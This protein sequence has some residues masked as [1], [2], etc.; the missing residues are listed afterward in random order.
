M[1]MNSLF[2]EDGMRNFTAGQ[3][4]SLVDWA[5]EARQIAQIMQA[6]LANQHID[7]D[8]GRAPNRR[9]RKVAR[10]QAK[11]AKLLEKA[12]AETEAL[13]AVYQ[14]EVTELPARRAR[15]LEQKATRKQ[16]LGIAATTVQDVAAK[17]LTKST[18][19]FTGI[20]PPAASSQVTPPPVQYVSP[21]P[22]AWPGQ[23]AGSQGVPSI[24]D[25]FDQEAM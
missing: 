17:S 12:A 21:Q 13:N 16:R 3:R 9:A 4:D 18:N 10:K 19:S 20:Q 23:T 14:R 1:D 5:G 24:H 2:T 11:V 8:T 25:V 6:R 7:G 15:Q 22:Y